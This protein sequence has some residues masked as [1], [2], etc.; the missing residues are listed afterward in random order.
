MP[1]KKKHTKKSVSK[2]T[3]H[4][5]KASDNSSPMNTSHSVEYCGVCRDKV[6]VSNITFVDLKVKNGTIRKRMAY[7]CVNHGHKWGK[8]VSSKSKTVGNSNNKKIVHTGG[9]NKQPQLQN[10]PTYEHPHVL[11]QIQPLYKVLPTDVS[12]LPE[13]TFSG[14]RPPKT[15]PPLPLPSQ[16][17]Q[18]QTYVPLSNFNISS[19]PLY[20]VLPTDVS[21]LPEPTFREQPPPPRPSKTSRPPFSGPQPPPLP[22]EIDNNLPSTFRVNPNLTRG[23]GEPTH[24]SLA[25]ARAGK[26]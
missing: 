6:K 18:A 9:A 3:K 17:T 11:K 7:M 14:P 16:L 25:N 8:F 1:S 5:A 4:T 24:Q 19:Q 23:S 10:N 26:T 20:N 12:K 21:K 22:L 2:H 15:S 13:P